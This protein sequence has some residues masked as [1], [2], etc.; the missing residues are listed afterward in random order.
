M[1]SSKLVGL[2][3]GLLVA[4]GCGD[5]GSEPTSND[6][7]GGA[8]AGANPGVGGSGASTSDGGQSASDGGGPATGGGGTGGNGAEIP[9]YATFHLNYTQEIDWTKCAERDFVVF[10]LEETPAD[11][12]AQCKG[13]GA[14][15]LCYFSSQYEEWRSDAGDFGALAEPIDGWPGENYVDPS[16]P[17][18]FEVMKA[19]LDVAA[20]KGC[21]GVDIDL[22]DHD[23]HED[24][25]ISIFTEARNR[26]LWVSQKN[27]PGKIDLFF[28]YVDLYQNEQCQEYDECAAYEGLG[29]PVHNIEY[30]PCHTLP[31]LYSH[32]KDVE[33][34]DAWEE[35]CAP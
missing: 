16:D 17:K 7:G 15:M 13:M 3:L 8:G 27:A 1:T 18:N 33:A 25:V 20:D 32:R 19:R 29:R 4:S 23:G 34:M 10:D 2:A 11:S 21:D 14:H 5:S 12:I 24:Y 26:G 35:P 28:D 30:T 31:Y 9:E 22:I 6:G